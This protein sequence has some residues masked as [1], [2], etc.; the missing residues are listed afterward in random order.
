MNIHSPNTVE[1]YLS[2]IAK[3]NKRY[4]GRDWSN[5]H[6]ILLTNKLFSEMVSAIVDLQNRVEELEADRD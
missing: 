5:R 2:I 1:E 3:L 6:S 4:K